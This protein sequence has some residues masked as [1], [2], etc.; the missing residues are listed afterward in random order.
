[1]VSPTLARGVP[2]NPTIRTLIVPQAPG[3]DAPFSIYVSGQVV[4]SL[5][6]EAAVDSAKTKLIGWERRFE[7]P[8]S[9]AR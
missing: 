7:P 3:T 6:F 9:R 8:V 5:R 1:M 2:E 4:T